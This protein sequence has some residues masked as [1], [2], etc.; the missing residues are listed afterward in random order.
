MDLTALAALRQEVFDVEL[1]RLTDAMVDLVRARSD[2]LAGAHGDDNP[3]FDDLW[4]RFGRVLCE[5]HLCQEI[6]PIRGGRNVVI[7]LQSGEYAF[8]D[9]STSEGV[10]RAQAFPNARTG[11]ILTT[12]KL[13]SLVPR[14]PAVSVPTVPD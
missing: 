4:G 7:N 13:F 5:R 14:P 10:A 8:V 2:F 9:M 6:E 1:M 12:G 11:F 3:A